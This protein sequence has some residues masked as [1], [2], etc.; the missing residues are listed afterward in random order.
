MPDIQATWK[1]T[2]FANTSGVASTVGQE[3][4][5]EFLSANPTNVAG[6]NRIWYNTT[7]FKLYVY[8]GTTQRASA[9]L[10]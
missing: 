10:A 7:D 2:A 4:T 9:A 8:D 6:V 1:Q 5:V 3:L